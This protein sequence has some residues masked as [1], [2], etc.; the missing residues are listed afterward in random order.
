MDPEIIEGT[1]VRVAL[2]NQLHHG[3]LNQVLEKMS[4]FNNELLNRRIDE[5]WEHE[6]NDNDLVFNSYDINDTKDSK[7]LFDKLSDSL[8]GTRA[9]DF[10][11]SIMHHL[12]MIQCDDDKR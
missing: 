9:E 8:R 7:E 11:H 6:E 1:E 3:G 2:R 4:I 5:F 10:F 12:L